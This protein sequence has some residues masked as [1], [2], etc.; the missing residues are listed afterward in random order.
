[1]FQ[2]LIVYMNSNIG[3]VWMCPGACTTVFLL[4]FILCVVGCWATSRVMNSQIMGCQSVNKANY[5]Y[6]FFRSTNFLDVVII[7][8]TNIFVGQ[9]SED[10]QGRFALLSRSSVQGPL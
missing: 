5:I 9:M 8:I 2:G 10:H 6:F 4:C 1:M 7:I 3:G